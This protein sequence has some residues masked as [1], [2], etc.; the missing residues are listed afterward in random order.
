MKTPAIIAS[1]TVAGSIAFGAGQQSGGKQPP[2]TPSEAQVH[3]MQ[4]ELPQAQLMAC[5]PQSEDWFSLVPHQIGRCISASAPQINPSGK[6]GTLPLGACDVNG[7]GAL[8]FFDNVGEIPIISETGAEMSLPVLLRSSPQQYPNG[9]VLMTHTVILGDS[10]ALTSALRQLEPSTNMVYGYLQPIGWRDMDQDG[11]QD[12]ICV[13]RYSGFG[14]V[15][16]AWQDIWFENV[17]FEKAAPPVAADLNGDG[18]VNGADLGLL[19][20]AW[21]PNP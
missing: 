19:L 6:V 21:G 7:D 10:A 4:E 5:Q 13:Y 18:Q 9:S 11:D 12:L 3:S 1:L 15:Q 20:V 17:G 2:S 8:E 16:F 14:G